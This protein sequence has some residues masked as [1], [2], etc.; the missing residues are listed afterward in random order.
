MYRQKGRFAKSTWI[1]IAMAL[2]IAVLIA[3]IAERNI[4]DPALNTPLTYIAVPQ[5]AEAA[6]TDA[7]KIETAKNKL[8]D[9]IFACETQGVKEPDAA[10]I[11]DTNGEMSIGAGM[12]QIK[13][14]QK[15][16]KEFTGKDIT[17]V[18]A[19]QIAI[20]HQKAHDL[21]YEII[22]K[23]GQWQNWLNCGTKVNAATTIK[24]LN[25]L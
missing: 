24:I 17:R 15:Y 4:V 20:D 19:I 3:I 1:K 14:V 10:I 16:T 25:S 11:L 21:A 5:K 22:W 6:E 13:T 8:V 2:C 9:D 23:D 12:F 18:E 7:S